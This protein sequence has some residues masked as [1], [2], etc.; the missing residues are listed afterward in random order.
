MA[1][2]EREEVM[3]IQDI[4]LAATLK[5]F[6][7]EYIWVE[8]KSISKEIYEFKFIRNP[9]L[10][11]LVDKYLKQELLIEPNIFIWIYKT[12]KNTL[13]LQMRR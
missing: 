9:E 5:Y 13:Y 6:G 4:V 8:L 1:I 12:F 11:S 3:Y 2:Q 10:D 7:C